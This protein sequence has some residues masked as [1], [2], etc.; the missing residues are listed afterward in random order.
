MKLDWDDFKVRKAETLSIDTK[1]S[2]ASQKRS[3]IFC[4]Y[5]IKSKTIPTKIY[6]LFMG[7]GKRV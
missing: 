2:A 4:E 3:L 7:Q 1:P 5:T 6:L